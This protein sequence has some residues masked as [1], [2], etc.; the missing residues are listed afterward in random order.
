[1][2]S[3]THTTGPKATGP[4]DHGLKPQKHEPRTGRVA[5]VAQCLPS[6][7]SKRE[8]LSSSPSTAKKNKKEPKQAF[9]VFKLI[10]SGF[11]IGMES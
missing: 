10:I 1:L 7:L 8:A 5:Q 3:G 11:V 9:S 2:P 6:K 4:T